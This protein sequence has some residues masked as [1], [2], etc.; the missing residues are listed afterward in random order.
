MRIATSSDGQIRTLEQALRRGELC[1]VLTSR[2]RGKS[3][4][5]VRA[6]ERLRAEGQAVA[7]IDLTAFGR[8]LDPEQWYDALVTRL[9][10]ELGLEQQFS[11]LLMDSRLVGLSVLQVPTGIRG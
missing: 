3:S 10:R 7:L 2:Q 9:G 11:W 5:M 6:A 4:L 8:N 1:Y